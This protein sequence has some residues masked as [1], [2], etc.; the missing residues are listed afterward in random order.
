MGA[1]LFYKQLCSLQIPAHPPNSN[2]N[3]GMFV[4]LCEWFVGVKIIV[5]N[6]AHLSKTGSRII[7][8]FEGSPTGLRGEGERTF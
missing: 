7:T 1:P 5:T 8:Q 3:V 6:T 2:S 4:R